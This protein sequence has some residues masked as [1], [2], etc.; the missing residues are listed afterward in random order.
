MTQIPTEGGPQRPLEEAGNLIL[1]IFTA[2][3]FYNFGTD[4]QHSVLNCVITSCKLTVDSVS[5]RTI[6]RY[7]VLYH[8]GIKLT[9]PSGM[10]HFTL[11]CV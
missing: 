8:T 7:T 10:T 6:I 3:I 1:P 5:V 11:I 4:I 2:S 9:S